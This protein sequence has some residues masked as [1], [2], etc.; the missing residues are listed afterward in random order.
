VKE[1]GSQGSFGGKMC[2]FAYKILM[3]VP[4]LNERDIFGWMS[5]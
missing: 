3:Q 5:E 1:E 2:E 4:K